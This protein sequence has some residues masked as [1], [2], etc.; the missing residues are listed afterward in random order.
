[1]KL[2]KRCGDSERRRDNRDEPPSGLFSS[3]TVE[4]VMGTND[5]IA[6][7]PITFWSWN[8]GGMA[9]GGVDHLT[10][11]LELVDWD[12]VCLQEVFRQRDSVH[13]QWKG[14]RLI[15][16][17]GTGRGSSAVLGSPR[18]SPFCLTALFGQIMWLLC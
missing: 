4:F 11:A 5:R 15:S 3:M 7:R 16:N 2:K 18:F 10:A 12:L 8:A 9:M 6:A 13:L 1:M 14:M 17:G